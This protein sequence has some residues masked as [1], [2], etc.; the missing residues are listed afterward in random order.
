MIGIIL[1]IAVVFIGVYLVNT[2]NG[3]VRL[4]EMVQN[5]MGQ[6]ATN[7][8]SRWDAIFNLISATKQYS[9]KEGEIL[10]DITRARAGISPNS[11]P[12]AVEE[13]EALFG[14]ALRSI[15]VVA[16]NYPQLRQSELYQ[17]TMNAVNQYE[18]NVRMSRQVYNDTVTRY[19]REIKVFPKNLIAGSMGFTEEEY[20]QAS[21]QK[22][23]MPMWD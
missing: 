17:S 4:K 12:E 18:N 3:L 21:R 8:E 13:D 11:S 7:I 6:I 9:Q 15:N 19:N 23:E 14:Q 20:F 1:L 10:T 22:T 2:Y 5:A 16:E